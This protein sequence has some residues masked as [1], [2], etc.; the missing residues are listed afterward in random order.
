MKKVVLSLSMC[1]LCGFILFG[2]SFGDLI[3]ASENIAK[4]YQR[5]EPIVEPELSAPGYEI[6]PL[7]LLEMAFGK[8]INMYTGT[9]A[10][11]ADYSV[12]NMDNYIEYDFFDKE[13]EYM[14]ESFYTYYNLCTPVDSDAIDTVEYEIYAD[15]T[16]TGIFLN[17]YIG[18]YDTLC[19]E[20]GERNIYEVS[21]ME[22][23]D[24]FEDAVYSDF[25]TLCSK[26]SAFDNGAYYICWDNPQYQIIYQV[27]VDDQSTLSNNHRFFDAYLTFIL[28]GYDS[29]D[30]LNGDPMDNIGSLALH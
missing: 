4:N 23:D 16:D 20:F 19:H 3:A 6:D 12:Y 25:E 1:V 7:G 5:N 24:S 10:E 29:A 18:F 13:F 9:L 2:C 11:D 8:D 21:Y 14:G 26:I 22:L 28:N 15:G 17:D 27:V 30:Y